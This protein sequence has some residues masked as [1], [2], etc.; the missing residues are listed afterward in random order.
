MLRSRQRQLVFNFAGWGLAV[1]LFGLPGWLLAQASPPAPDYRADFAFFWETVRDHYAYFDGRQ[2]NWACVRSRYQPRVDTLHRRADFVRVLEQALA[3]LYDHH[4]SLGTNQPDSW[5]LVPTGTDLYAEW[6]GGQARVLAVRPGFGAARAGVQ[7]GMVVTAVN[8]VPVAQAAQPLR[9]HCL[10]RDDPA[11]RNFALNQLL[12][13]RHHTP[14]QLTLA[15]ATGLRTVRPDEFANQLEAYPYA[16]RLTV[17][18]YGQL[19]YIR[20]NN[21]LGDDELIAAFDSALTTLAGT[22]G[23]VLDLR[24]TPSGGNTT[25]ARAIM[26][27]FL[28]REQPY[29]RHELPAEERETGIRRRWL[30][31]VSPRPAPYRA[32]LVVLAGRWTGSMGEGLAVGLRTVRQAPVVGTALARL[33]GAV[34]SYRLPSTGIGFNIPA[35]RLSLVGGQ[36]RETYVPDVVVAPGGHPGGPTPDAT[37]NRGLAMLKAASASRS[38]SHGRAAHSR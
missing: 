8:G 15:T 12:A 10:R 34:Y 1:A 17:A 3:E 4:A 29:Q 13:G 19:G 24:E 11:A 23:L 31:L 16:G 21:S 26:G 30:E 7:P 9:P 35:E 33:A 2:T 36:P 22:R 6:V 37:L 32:P 5:R 38:T 28:T 14:R 25:V 18:R 20:V 27:R